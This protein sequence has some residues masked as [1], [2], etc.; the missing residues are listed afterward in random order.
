MK[1]PLFAALASVLLTPVLFAQKTGDAVTPA[2]L[3]KLDWIRGS[4]PAAW[5]PGKLYVFECWATWC[6]PCLAVIPHMDALHDK[7]ESKGLRVTGVNVWEDGRDMV[8]DFVKKKGDGMSYP[9]AY[10]GKGGAFETEWLKPAEVRGIPHAF[11]V[12]DGK[13]LFT[14]H[15]SQLKESVIE[16]LLAG[17]EAETKVI[18]GLNAAA[19]K[20]AKV[21]GLMKSFRSAAQQKDQDGMAKALEELKAH[22]EAALYV[23]AL[24]LELLIARSD[25][26]GT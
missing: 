5:E 25:W 23:P 13:V 17:G 9:I 7:Y 20:R 15:P 3:A 12:K 14:T 2:A 11:V 16:D 19:E 24:N 22:E 10:T 4:A 6:G 8:A 26:A 18:A 21:S 1:T